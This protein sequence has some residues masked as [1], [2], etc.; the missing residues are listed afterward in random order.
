MSLI[1]LVDDDVAVTD[2][3]HFADQPRPR[4]AVLE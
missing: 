1:H 3:C 4:R 2:A